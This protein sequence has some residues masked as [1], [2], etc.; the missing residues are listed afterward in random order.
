[1]PFRFLQTREFAAVQPV[2]LA[3][4]LRPTTGG[5]YRL[6]PLVRVELGALRAGDVIDV[7]ACSV[8]VSTKLTH[9]TMVGSHL[10]LCDSSRTSAAFSQ[11]DFGRW[12]E[13]TEEMT[14]NVT[15]TDHHHPIRTSGRYVVAEDWDNAFLVFLVYAAWP[16]WNGTS[17]LTVD[18]DFGRLEGYVARPITAQELAEFIAGGPAP[19][20]D[21]PPAPEPPPPAPAPEPPAPAPEPPPAPP[22]EP[23]LWPLSLQITAAQAAALQEIAAQIPATP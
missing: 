5:P 18:R 1:M 13:V 9:A 22:P 12:V 10:I 3:T 7:A 23:E 6:T 19:E 2:E 21:E 14:T 8:Q 16:T 11:N 17:T 15:A 4:T 20:P